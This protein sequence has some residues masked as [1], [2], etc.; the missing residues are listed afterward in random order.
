L[1][2]GIISFRNGAYSENTK[3]G[4][5]RSDAL[6]TMYSLN[7]FGVFYTHHFNIFENTKIQLGY[8]GR[9]DNIFSTK[10]DRYEHTRDGT[11][12]MFIFASST[13]NKHSFK[14]N[15]SR[16]NVYYDNKEE[17]TMDFGKHYMAGLGYQ[18][19]DRDESGN[20]LYGILAMSISDFDGTPLSPTG[21][22]LYVPE[23][24]SFSKEGHRR[25]YSALI[26]VKKDFDQIFGLDLF[27][28]AEYFYASKYWVS[29]VT[30][31]HTI[32]EYNRGMLG[33][34]QK[35]FAGIKITPKFNISVTGMHTRYDYAS[36]LGGTDV[37]VVDEDDYTMFL[38]FNLMF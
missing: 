2:V 7:M 6:S 9:Q 32:Y 38:K 24:A 34:T 5:Q 18:Y 8:V 25:G 12:M 1:T 17:I 27:T 4:I 37:R 21:K 3:L 23:R 30:D 33:H 15:A 14:F 16:S 35:I 20:L 31:S 28:G 22:P 26:G 36:L 13:Y 19:D 10:E 29:Y 11:D